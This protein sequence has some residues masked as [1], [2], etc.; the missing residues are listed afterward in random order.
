[1]TFSRNR[2]R[3]LSQLGVGVTGAALL[4]HS[5]AGSETENDLELDER[6]KKALRLRIEIAKAES[7]LKTLPQATN[8]DSER[9][10]SHL[11]NFSKGFKHDE[12]D[13]PDAY[14]YELYLK[15]L[16]SGKWEDF[17]DIP[18]GGSA[19]LSDPMA[20]YAYSLEGADSHKSWTPPFAG[21]CKRRTGSRH[22]RTL[23]ARTYA[24]CIILR[25]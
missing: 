23:L 13:L 4:G 3:F 17:E 7:K 2:R 9:Y 10:P 8:G 5:G 11:A 25:V 21:V 22:D 18:M 20:A 16:S 24:G 15:A 12:L 14:D 6:A 19:K 1:M